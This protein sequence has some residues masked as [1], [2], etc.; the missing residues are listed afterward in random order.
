MVLHCAP[1]QAQWPRFFWL[2]SCAA[3][4]GGRFLRTPPPVKLLLPSDDD[5]SFPRA[6]TLPTTIRSLDS[7]MWV[8]I[9][10]IHL[11]RSID[12]SCGTGGAVVRFRK[13]KWIESCRSKATGG[14]SR[15]TRVWWCVLWLAESASHTAR[16]PG[17]RHHDQS[18]LTIHSLVPIHSANTGVDPSA[19]ETKGSQARHGPSF[20]ST[21][22]PR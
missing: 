9:K 1:E 6:R 16:A 4:G 14:P 13:W 2:F 10:S 3:G 19:A 5:L 12:R 17:H 7:T 15:Y 21:R 22:G 20:I 8:R 18:T 11:I